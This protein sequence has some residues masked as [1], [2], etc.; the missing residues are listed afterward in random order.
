[1]HRSAQLL[2]DDKSKY[3]DSIAAKS[4]VKKSFICLPVI[5]KEAEPSTTASSRI[6]QFFTCFSDFCGDDAGPG[7]TANCLD[8]CN[9]G[10]YDVS[11][12]FEEKERGRKKKKGDEKERG[13]SSN[14]E[15]RPLFFPVLFFPVPFFLLFFLFSLFSCSSSPNF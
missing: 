12:Q 2:N 5:S 4:V 11:A 1:M 15:L 8:C 7:E 14:N 10:A 9:H 6:L 13:R 3:S